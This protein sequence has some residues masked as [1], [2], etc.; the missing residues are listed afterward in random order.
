L[1][2]HPNSTNAKLAISNRARERAFI[3]V[4]LAC[5]CASNATVGRSLRQQVVGVGSTTEELGPERRL[6]DLRR[7][8]AAVFRKLRNKL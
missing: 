7:H 1:S 2:E 5:E 3:G 8:L 4:L 6:D